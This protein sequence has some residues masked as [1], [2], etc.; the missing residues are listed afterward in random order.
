[1][2]ANEILQRM[3]AALA[4]RAEA[5]EPLAQIQDERA[6]LLR[7]IAALDE[8]YGKAYADAEAAGWTVEE[9]TELGIGEPARRPKG[10]PRSRRPVTAKKS[11]PA[12]ASPAAVPAQDSPGNAAP[13]G[14][15][16]QSG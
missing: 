14:A 16:T 3:Q 4:A 7:Q 12:T 5:I 6:E 10:R 13:V 15:D 2:S 9:L 1:M 8:P 11:T